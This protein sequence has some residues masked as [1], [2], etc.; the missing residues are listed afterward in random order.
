MGNDACYV[1]GGEAFYLASVLVDVFIVLLLSN[2]EM[3]PVVKTVCESYFRV[4]CSI[5][6]SL[7]E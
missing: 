1:S 3:F 5:V 7:L 2:V 6:T 4:I